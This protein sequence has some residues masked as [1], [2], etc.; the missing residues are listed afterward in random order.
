[1]VMIRNASTITSGWAMSKAGC[2]CE[3]IIQ[4][5][6]TSSR[7]PE[8]LPADVGG[9]EEQALAE[10]GGGNHQR[11]EEDHP[12][13][14]VVEGLEDLGI[15]A[16]LETEGLPRHGDVAVPAQLLRRRGGLLEPVT[17]APCAEARDPGC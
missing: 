9:G 4:I 3:M 10:E 6:S 5:S 16:R 2:T 8:E 7:Q 1:M 13:D 15:D 11:Q 17:G 12:L 14:H